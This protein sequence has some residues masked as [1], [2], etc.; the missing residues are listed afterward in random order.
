M[1]GTASGGAG[2]SPRW[3]RCRP[4]RCAG[5]RR[6]PGAGRAGRWTAPPRPRCSPRS[7]RTRCGRCR[8]SRS[9]WPRWSRAK[10][11]PDIHVKVD[12]ALYSVPWRHIGKTVDARLTATMVQ[13]F[14]DGQ[15][16]KTHPRKVRGKQTDFGDYPPEKIAFLMRT[17]AWCRTPGRRRSA[18][19]ASGHRRAARRQ[20]AATGCAPPRASSAWPTGTT[21]PAR[22][23]LRQG[24]RR[25]A[26]RPTAPS[27]AS[28]P[29]APNT[30]DRPSR[31]APTAP[32]APARPPAAVRRD[33]AAE[34]CR[35]SAPNAC[36]PHPR[37]AT[38]STSDTVA[39]DAPGDRHHQ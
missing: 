21:R 19:P 8:P 38:R 35:M 29:P 15:L 20:R 14:I 2:S 9:C 34:A 28:S 33:G 6:S 24:D 5:A 12:K 17:P 32:G 16:V 18:R 27:R 36:I 22:R 37:P 3:R 1:S 4:R 30:R 10:V 7:R 25:S 31:R 13:F 26:T 39:P 11:G 23:R